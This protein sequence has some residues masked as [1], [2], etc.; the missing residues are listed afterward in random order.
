MA[1][2]VPGFPQDG[3][4]D[5]PMDEAARRSPEFME[6][7]PNWS[8][9]MQGMMTLLRV[10]PPE[11]YQRYLAGERKAA[12][13]GRWAMKSAKTILAAT[14]FLPLLLVPAQTQP[15]PA[16][17]SSMPGMQMEKPKERFGG[18]L[19]EIGAQATATSGPVYQLDALEAEALQ[20][21]PTLTQADASL[22]SSQGRKQQAG[23]W[24][25][26]TIGYFGDEISGGIGV[27]GG[28]HGGFIEQTI[29]LGRKLYLAQQ[30]A[31][32]D[33]KLATLAKEEQRYR[34]QN[35]VRVAYFQT[36]A[37]QAMLSLAKARVELASKML[38]TAHRL[39]NAGSRDASEVVMA[40]IESERDQLGVDV[41]Q[42]QVRQQWDTLRAIVGD[43][44]LPMGTLA[45]RLDADL[46]QIDPQQSVTLLLSESPAMQMAK[47]SAAR[48][49]NSVEVARRRAVPDLQLK[50]G[51]EQNFETNDLTGR[52]F[53]LQGVAEARVELPIFNRNQ[54]AVAAAHAEFESSQAESRRLELEL[55]RQASMVVEEYESARLTVERYRN[56]ILPRTRSLY[57]MQQQAWGRMALSYPQLLLAQ[58]NLID[59]Q[60]EYI[61]ALVRLRTN[62]VALS[63]FLLTDELRQMRDVGSLNQP[64][65]EA[66]ESIRFSKG[67]SA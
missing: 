47:E 19:A 37:A 45:G 42:A 28:R 15:A 7:P 48:A 49:Q 61:H 23:A 10:M 26:P 56:Q 32:S 52:A 33:V 3:F 63:G 18:L 67:E 5:M 20:R 6:L 8:A 22:R 60:A 17:S 1:T 30:V 59:A 29:V 34:V 38:D 46:P 35:N 11:K 40:E 9:G 31:G 65:G 24:P 62:A 57:E 64:Q 66:E 14:I 58:Q 54:G 21:N 39:Q 27:N 41:Q 53:G 16:Q 4:M 25:N 50:A 36:L 43:P 13:L 44:S 55:R 12:A 51:L 2:K